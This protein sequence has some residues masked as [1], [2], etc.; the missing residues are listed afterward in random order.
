MTSYTTKSKNSRSGVS[1]S[2][3]TIMVRGQRTKPNKANTRQHK[4]ADIFA[5]GPKSSSTTLSSWSASSS[6]S[7]GGVV[8][9]LKY[10]WM[11]RGTMTGQHSKK[12]KGKGTSQRMNHSKK[13]MW[14]GKGETTMAIDTHTPQKPYAYDWK[15]GNKGVVAAIASGNF[16]KKSKKKLRAKRKANRARKKKR[17]RG[18]GM[19]VAP[20]PSPS[21]SI[22]PSDSRDS[23]SPTLPRTPA[24]TAPPTTSPSLSPVALW[25]G[26]NLGQPTPRDD[27]KLPA[28]RCNPAE[29]CRA[30]QS[31]V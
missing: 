31:D 25:T 4:A 10:M 26:D 16:K 28:I 14:M 20:S 8:K 21:V 17:F 23:L 1:V 6:H 11:G 24:P 3:D 13:F 30:C 9:S 2:K 12:F 7:M 22:A 18:K 27:E 19:Q 15:R 29:P 5:M